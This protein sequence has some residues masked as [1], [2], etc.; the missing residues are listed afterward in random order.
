MNILWEPVG[1]N[2]EDLSTLLIN[3]DSVYSNN[4]GAESGTTIS[5]N[6]VTSY[7]LIQNETY[8]IKMIFKRDV[9]DKDWAITFINPN[10]GTGI[11]PNVSFYAD[12]F[13]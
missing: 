6:K 5:F 4:S 8:V 1:H 13:N 7:N 2:N 10:T 9:E 11:T 12:D 3:D